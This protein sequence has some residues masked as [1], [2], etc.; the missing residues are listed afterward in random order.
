MRYNKE[1][2]LKL[3]MHFENNHQCDDFDVTYSCCTKAEH[4]LR[5]N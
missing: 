5:V 2:V 3:K 1:E 4:Q